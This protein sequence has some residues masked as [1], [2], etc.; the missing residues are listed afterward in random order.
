MVKYYFILMFQVEMFC[1]AVLE[2]ILRERTTYFLESNNNTINFWI[3]EQ[4]AFFNDLISKDLKLEKTVG[5]T[6]FGKKWRRAEEV[7]DFVY[8]SAVISTN[9]LFINWLRLRLGYFDEI[10]HITSFEDALNESTSDGIYGAFDE[11]ELKSCGPLTAGISSIDPALTSY[12]VELVDKSMDIWEMRNNLV[13][14][15]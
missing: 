5:N 11:S 3:L 4:P 6:N 1:S 9:K 13:S 14:S 10:T 8:Y 15:G 12:L 7:G 2:E